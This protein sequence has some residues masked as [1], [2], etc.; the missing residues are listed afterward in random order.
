MLNEGDPTGGVPTLLDIRDVCAALAC[1]RTAVER[2]VR[3]GEL[4]FLKL[5]HLTRFRVQDLS[6]FI[7]RLV[8]QRRTARAEITAVQAGARKS[9]SAI[10]KKAH[11]R[12][13]REI[14]EQ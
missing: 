7:D 3:R 12:S 9:P 14:P 6:A 10:V 5:G 8:G 1:S 2:L 11:T 13:A 4:P